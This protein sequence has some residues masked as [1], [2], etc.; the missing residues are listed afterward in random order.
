LLSHTN[1][2]IE[3]HYFISIPKI[4][5]QTVLNMIKSTFKNSSKLSSNVLD[6]TRTAKRIFDNIDAQT[7]IQGYIQVIKSDPFGFFTLCENQV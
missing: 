6:V 2:I 7:S 5:K 4:T 3:L 1:A